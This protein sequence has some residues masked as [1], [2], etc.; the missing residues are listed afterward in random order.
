MK[1]R[2]IYGSIIIFCSNSRTVSIC[3][4]VSVMYFLR[5]CD[6]CSFL[7][8]TRFTGSIIICTTWFSTSARIC[9]K[10]IAFTRHSKTVQVSMRISWIFTICSRVSSYILVVPRDS[11]PR[12]FRTFI[13]WSDS[14]GES[15]DDFL[16]CCVLELPSEYWY[17]QPH[18]SADLHLSQRN[19]FLHWEVIN[20]DDPNSRI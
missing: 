2:M 16:N 15:A 12:I 14:N 1:E 18:V 3:P 8:R 19:F 6:C 10:F 7:F 11:K 17:L 5:T 4:I 20:A 9:M 13:F